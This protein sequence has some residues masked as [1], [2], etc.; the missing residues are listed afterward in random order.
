LAG[1]AAGSLG[2]GEM[3]GQHQAGGFQDERIEPE[4][5]LSGGGV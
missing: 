2:G 3:L 1:A 5:D 4:R